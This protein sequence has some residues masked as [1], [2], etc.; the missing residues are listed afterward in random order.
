M[1][2]FLLR[3]SKNPCI[4]VMKLESHGGLLAPRNPRGPQMSS[5]VI[6]MNRHGLA[7]C[8]DSALTVPG[9]NGQESVYN[10]TR[11]IFLASRDIGFMS[12]N[13]VDHCGLRLEVILKKFR[14]QMR[15]TR[16][17]TL[18]Q[19]SRRFFTHVKGMRA[20]ES[21]MS[22]F[23]FEQLVF[24]LAQKISGGGEIRETSLKTLMSEVKSK[25]VL[26]EV[27]GKEFFREN[28]QL[29]LDALGEDSEPRALSAFSELCREAVC[30]S[31]RSSCF[32]GIVF[33]G[34]GKTQDFPCLEHWTLD[35]IYKGNLRFWLVDAKDLNKPGS[36]SAYII[37]FA[38]S[39]IAD[40]VLTGFDYN[41]INRLKNNIRN[42]F[43]KLAV[44]ETD[45]N[46]TELE[47]K[48]KLD[49]SL[50]ELQKS[51][52]DMAEKIISQSVYQRHINFFNR[53][54]EVEKTELAE[55]GKALVKI[56][57]MRRMI[58]QDVRTVGGP[59][60]VSVITKSD[61]FVWLKRKH[62]F[63]GKL[64]PNFVTEWSEKYIK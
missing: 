26:F 11:K 59:I 51:L 36:E 57:A 53:I 54:S 8:S 3:P 5:Q 6:V 32:S 45:Y 41:I 17:Q 42:F 43:N 29:L 55:I 35:G 33:A 60:D 64:N 7:M 9:Q 21:S 10:N 48:I 1:R 31:Y 37:P 49:P 46:S 20:P 16:M 39:D 24:D 62:Y 19:C 13:A 27:D 34:Y 23:N 44:D 15:G 22:S 18:S 58:D 56:T 12:Y 4:S 30:R 52:G 47:D 50:T 14:E 63:K 40:L 61:G 2:I 25:E 28:K 38:Q